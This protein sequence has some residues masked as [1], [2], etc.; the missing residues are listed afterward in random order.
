M[1][2][3]DRTHRRTLRNVFVIAAAAITMTAMA[4]F[5]STSAHAAP[6]QLAQND[7]GTA[8]TPSSGGM[9]HHRRHHMMG[10]ESIDDR[11]KTLHTELKITPAEEASW[12]IVAQTMR[13]N[14]AT[15]KKMV[16]EERAHP[17]QSR[18]AL[19]DLKTYQRFVQAHADGIRKLADAFTV[20]YQAM[21][22]EQQK[23]ADQ[24]FARHEH[25]GM[26]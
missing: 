26:R 4:P 15:M 10:P 3:I 17:A 19:E 20:L 18:T 23:I 8:Q 16:D 2:S 6:L 24:V 12:G 22:P 25:R 7:A 21:S 5:G 11:I 14:A 1:K 13:D 9:M